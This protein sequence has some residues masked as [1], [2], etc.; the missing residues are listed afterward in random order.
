ML[1]SQTLFDCGKK[2]RGIIT[3]S[4]PHHDGALPWVSEPNPFGV[5]IA[6]QVPAGTSFQAFF[7]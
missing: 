7:W 2:P 6:V 1:S 5:L 4:A 3:V